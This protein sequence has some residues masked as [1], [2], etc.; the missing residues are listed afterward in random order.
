MLYSIIF[1]I[2][3]LAGIYLRYLW[4]LYIYD[5]WLKVCDKYFKYHLNLTE[6]DKAEY[7][8]VWPKFSIFVRFWEFNFEKFIINQDKLQEVK[9][10][11]AQKYGQNF[12]NPR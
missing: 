9:M 6:E 10:F 5:M 4:M 11:F 8:Q 2:V 7:V 12:H 1:L 3:F